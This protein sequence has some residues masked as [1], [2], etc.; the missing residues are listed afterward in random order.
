MNRAN[1]QAIR[2]LDRPF[3]TLENIVVLYIIILRY[4][5]ST[6]LDK[7][8]FRQNFTT[9]TFVARIYIYNIEL[10][11]HTYLKKGT[12]PCMERTKSGEPPMTS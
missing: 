3:K 10:H 6:C 1:V 7:Y 2:T 12:I 9:Y 5:G 4:Y 11:F 8:S